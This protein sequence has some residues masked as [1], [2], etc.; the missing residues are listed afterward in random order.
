MTDGSL[1]AYKS[2]WRASLLAGLALMLGY[3]YFN[4]DVT[5][6]G[7][8]FIGLIY[9]AIGLVAILLLLFL[10]V[11][12]RWY[13]SRLGTVQ[14]WTSAHIYLGLLTLL[15][16]PMHAGFHFGWNVHSLA[17]ALLVLTVLSGM[18]GVILYLLVPRWLTQSESGMLPDKIESEI[19]RLLGEMEVLASGKFG[20]FRGFYLGEMQRARPTKM[21]G[22][23]I[24]FRGLD[25][26][27]VLAARTQEFSKFVS[28]IPKSDQEDYSQ[29]FGLVLKKAEIENALAR[30]MR[31]K[32]A[33]EVWL[34]VHVPASMALLVAVAIH[35]IVVMTY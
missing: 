13:T 16:I 21:M 19:N 10:G 33:L 28:K 30:Q 11:R 15:I 31:L 9:G 14:G 6:S 5:P 35:L 8:T 12:K 17:F 22:W 2:Y 20:A 32:N 25:R 34:F 18:V 7:A 24:L 23:R 27:A 1:L 26:T 29:F 4:R 3:I